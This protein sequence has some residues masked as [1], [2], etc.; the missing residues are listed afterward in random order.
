MEGAAESWQESD[1]DRYILLTDIAGSSRLSEA[2]PKP[3]FSALETHNGIIEGAV[4][5]HQGEILKNLGDGYLAVFTDAGNALGAAVDLQLALSAPQEA[6]TFPDGTRLGVRSVVHGGRLT[7]LAGQEHD[8]FGPPLNRC[9][10]IAEVCHPGQILISDIVRGALAALLPDLE[11]LD[12]GHVRLRDLGEP[13]RLYQVTHPGFSQRQF[14]PLRSLD[15]RPHN[16]AAQPNIFFGRDRELAEIARML[17]GEQRL[18]T[19]HAPGGYG[20]SR[21]A[22]QLLAHELWRYEHGAFQVLLAPLTSYERLPEAIAG[23]IGFSFYDSR[24]PKRQL[25]DY[26]RNKEMLLCLDNFEHVLAGANIVTEIYQS[27]PKLRLL[28]TSREPLR[29]SAE[30]VYRLEPLPLGPSSDAVQLFADRCLRVKQ[31]FRLNSQT[32]P[33]VER[34]CA[35]MEGVPLALELAAAWADGFTL[36]EMDAELERQLDINARLAD[37]P[38]RQRSVRAS[39]DWSYKLLRPELQQALMKLATF[40]G[41]FFA[42]AA[43]AVLDLQGMPLRQTLA[44]LCDKSWLFTREVD[45]RTRYAIR[46]AAAHEYAWEKLEATREVT[47]NVSGA[48]TTGCQQSAG[49]TDGDVNAALAPSSTY[50]Q[51][52]LD[53]ARYFCAFTA[54]EGPRLKGDGTPD[55]QLEALGRWKLE[56]ANINRALDTALEYHDATLLLPFAEHLDR[57]LR[58]SCDFAQRREHADLLAAEAQRLNHPELIVLAMWAQNWNTYQDRATAKNCFTQTLELAKTLARRDLSAYM[59]YALGQQYIY[60]DNSAAQSHLLQALEL[61]REVGDRHLESQVLR[62][63]GVSSTRGGMLFSPDSLPLWQQSIRISRD[64]GDR[65]GEADTL[66]NLG[67]YGNQNDNHAVARAHYEQ[68]LAIKRS[69]GDKAGEARALNNLGIC[70]SFEAN[71]DA[72]RSYYEQVVELSHQIG[73]IDFEACA[74]LNLGSMSLAQDSGDAARALFE[75][76]LKVARDGNGVWEVDALIM[77]GR[78]DFI[79]GELAAAQS[80]LEEALAVAQDRQSNLSVSIRVNYYIALIKLSQGDTA[81]AREPLMHALQECRETGETMLLPDRFVAAGALL[82]LLGVWRAAT[83]VLDGGQFHI[84]QLDL[85]LERELN[86]LLDSSYTSIDAAIAAGELTPEEVAALKIQA[87]AM[88]IVELTDYAL[89]SLVET[90]PAAEA[91]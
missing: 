84:A 14:P 2:Y 53:H 29:L 54:K 56:L 16:L 57:Y 32:S 80:R 49:Q 46:D 81:A 82:S 65:Y 19:L 52:I 68:M 17:N 44:A 8:W 18:V 12:L 69:L 33:W 31:D 10:R 62:L 59:L 58:M 77:L 60:D 25:L 37:V 11:E 42:D 35:R 30:R 78:V 85:T 15:S 51:A 5:Q 70:E 50:E 73:Y 24:E 83:A 48:G 72:A 36:P 4:Q 87:E 7:R 43:G 9:A 64:I 3:Y 6:F 76:A 61:A 39:C 22:S 74:L 41:G 1:T 45:G 38:E 91:T 20:K 13:Q 55:G 23:A 27:A 90:M 40:R 79:E 63:L 75:R 71:L 86:S 47:P 88:S 66:F 34:I 67:Q 28:V 21:L 26:L 89:N